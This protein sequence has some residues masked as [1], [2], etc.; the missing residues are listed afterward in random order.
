LRGEL[1]V[2]YT[3]SLLIIIAKE[4]EDAVNM[5]QLLKQEQQQIFEELLK[6]IFVSFSTCDFFLCNSKMM[7]ECVA[8][9]FAAKKVV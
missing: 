6:I 4:E 5:Q 1:R 8:A 3:V 9:Y 7:E 2:F